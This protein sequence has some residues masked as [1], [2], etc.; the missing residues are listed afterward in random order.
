VTVPAD[1]DLNSAIAD[2]EEGSVVALA[3]DVSLT[4][5]LT[6]NKNMTLDLGGNKIS[7]TEGKQIAVPSGVTLT[8]KG[9]TGSVEGI[10]TIISVSG[11]L[12]I[13]GGNLKGGKDG[14]C[15]LGSKGT[16]TVVVNGGTFTTN[17]G[18]Y[19][20]IGAFENS[21]VIINGGT[22]NCPISVS[23][24]ATIGANGEPE[25]K[26]A[27]MIING[28]VFNGTMEN[29]PVIFWPVGTLSVYGGEFT[30]NDTVFAICGG[31]VRLYGGKI[32]TTGDAA[33]S[34]ANSGTFSDSESAVAVIAQRKTAYQ[35]T[36]LTISDNVEITVPADK[37]AVAVYTGDATNAAAFGTK[38]DLS[39]TTTVTVNGAAGSITLN[40]ADKF[41]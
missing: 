11:N 5:T 26:Y 28:G 33:S 41:K 12:V 20:A 2:A 24:N 19:Y 36:G 18:A 15:M 35:L 1:G 21:T 10:S 16:G 22:F 13:E 25:N 14:A 27:Q 32:T 17:D 4:E 30:A 8:I 40:I 7:V 39:T 6:V 9:D 23:A 38:V 37:T 34:I 3:G 31:N 29:E